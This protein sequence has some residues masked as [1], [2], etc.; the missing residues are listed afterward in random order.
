MA[1]LLQTR[2]LSKSF[3]GLV[4]NRH[5]DLELEGGA[6]LCV[7]GPNGA[8]KTTLL[9]LVSGHERPTEGRILYRGEDI[10]PLP[11]EERA[12]LGVARKFQTPSVF[13]ELTAFQNI[14]LAAMRGQRP[15]ARRHARIL[16]V[17]DTVRLGA[18]RRVPAQFLSH[19]QRQWLEIGMLMAMDARL[20]LLD[21][22]AAGMMAE[23]TAATVDLVRD[24]SAEAG[25]SVIVIEHDMNFVRRLGAPVM[26]LHL[27]SVLAQGS[28]EAIAA[29]R[30]VQEAYLGKAA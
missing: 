4:A 6:T 18:Q 20:F 13:H 23:E 27:G 30:Q 3:K 26:V 22:P 15:A 17:L 11:V 1:M 12:R 28:F 24:I 14:E 21:E 16:E 25:T 19:G 8:G 10:T 5:I 29:D 2:G 9:S 7:I